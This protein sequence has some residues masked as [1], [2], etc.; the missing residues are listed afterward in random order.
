MPLSYFLTRRTWAACSSGA[1]FLWITPMPPCCAI[2][3]AM[4]SSVTVSMADDISGMFSSMRRVSRARTSVAAGNTPE[5]AGTTSTSSKAS[6]SLMRWELV[7]NV[8][9]MPEP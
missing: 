1:R 9:A 7:E 6:A 4:P 5:E 3:M 2:A 8:P